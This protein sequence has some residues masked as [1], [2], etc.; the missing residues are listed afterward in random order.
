MRSRDAKKEEQEHA[1]LTC[2]GQKVGECDTG[3]DTSSDTGRHTSSDSSAGGSATTDSN[4]IV[5]LLLDALHSFD[6]ALCDS[7][8][9]ASAGHP[10]RSEERDQAE[11]AARDAD[12]DGD[13]LALDEDSHG[14]APPRCPFM[15]SSAARARRSQSNEPT[16][17]TQSD[18]G[19]R[20]Q[21]DLSPENAGAGAHASLLFMPLHAFL[22][23]TSTW[24]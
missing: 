17:A 4:D 22:Y 15:R 18:S 14:A 2:G 10:N 13:K 12:S 3:S 19:A 7:D 21:A 24:G 6:S 8:V 5:D 1:A 9:T 11:V 23:S 16:G 20:G